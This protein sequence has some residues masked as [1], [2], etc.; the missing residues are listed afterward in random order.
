[1]WQE[2]ALP[3]DIARLLE[4]PKVLSVLAEELQV[5]D[6]RVLWYLMKLE[7][8]GWVVREGEHWVR[9]PGGS[10]YAATTQPVSEDCTVLPGRTAYD[11]QQAYADAAAGMFGATYVQAAGEHG[12]RVPYERA[13]EFNRRLLEL[14]GEYFA[15]ESVDRAASP[16]YGFHWVL[17]PTDL[18]PLSDGR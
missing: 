1:M 7:E 16:K 4:A 2:S 8:A 18:H 3:L 11:Y 13:V 17:T 14:I 9:T 15:P 10:E 5:T 12:G 6:A